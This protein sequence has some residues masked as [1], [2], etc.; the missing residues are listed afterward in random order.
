MIPQ[1]AAARYLNLE[2][3]RKDGSGVKTPVWAALVDD[4]LV[5][6]TDGSTFKVKRIRANPKVRVAACN[7]SGKQVLGPWY[8]AT[9]RIVEP[10][11]A[12]PAEAALDAR[13]GWQRRGFRFFAKLFGRMK[14]PVIIEVTIPSGSATA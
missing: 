6:G 7:A 13:Y 3:F 10:G 11:A 5:V 12:A 4:K 2:T 1:L 8:D 9:A 14:D